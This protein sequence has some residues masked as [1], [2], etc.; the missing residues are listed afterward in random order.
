MIQEKFKKSF[1][2]V[3]NA[4]S[5]VKILCKDPLYKSKEG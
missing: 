2:S 5:V 1:L 3:K 4:F